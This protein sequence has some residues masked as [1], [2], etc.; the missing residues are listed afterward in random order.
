MVPK[1]PKVTVKSV[2]QYPVQRFTDHQLLNTTDDIA[3][4]IAVAMVYNGISHV[5]MMSTPSDLE[6]LALGFSLSEKIIEH[7]DE[8]REI[9]Q[10]EQPLGIELNITIGAQAI[11][12]LK[13]QRRNMT[14]RTGCGLCGAESL[15]Q[16]MKT[17]P[18]ANNQRSAKVITPETHSAIQH[19]IASLQSHQ[20]LQQLT[21]AV[22]GAAWCDNTGNILLLRED[23]G[24]HNALDKLIGALTRGS[25]DLNQG[26]VLISSRASYEMI[27]KAQV[28]GI[29]MVVAVSAPTA[30]AINIAN[31]VGMILVGFARDGRHTFYS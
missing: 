8:I 4:E 30:L 7:P 31:Q 22:H 10:V 27:S 24:R 26:F 25:Y 12:A 6:D 28:A 20:P 23:I 19:A 18:T 14:G 17:L 13:Q 2:A 9:T 21:G 29:S 1:E 15:Q 5:V 16:A 3:Q 11:W